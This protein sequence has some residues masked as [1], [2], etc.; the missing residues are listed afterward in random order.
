M[1]LRQ[2]IKQQECIQMAKI[3]TKQET[4]PF[5]QIITD[6]IKKNNVNTT[7][8]TIVH[9]VTETCKVLKIIIKANTIDN[10][11]QMPL[12]YDNKNTE[13]NFMQNLSN[14]TR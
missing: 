1:T 5:K 7:K 14:E 2:I 11:T 3:L 12:W 13:T 6:L 9:R 10:V 8:R 4:M